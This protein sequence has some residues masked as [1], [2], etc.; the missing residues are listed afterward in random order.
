ME[1]ALEKF[2]QMRKLCLAYWI[3]LTV[4][5]IVRN[6]LALV[7]GSRSLSGAI[8]VIEPMVHFLSFAGLA[9]LCTYADWP[10]RRRWLLA[11]IAVYAF[12]TEAVQRYIPGR[13]AEFA[14][15]L[16]NLAGLAVGAGVGWCLL[17]LRDAIGQWRASRERAA[18][19]MS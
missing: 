14:D 1:W 6:P 12:L 13:T 3:A 8:A 16:Q 2:E 10:I 15:L 11:M 5:L 9:A 7:P 18:E 19:R 4:G 17:C